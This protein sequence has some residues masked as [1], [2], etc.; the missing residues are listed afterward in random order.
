MK[1]II[2]IFSTV[3]LI[4]ISCQLEP[5]DK[6][7]KNIADDDSE[8]EKITLEEASSLFEVE[9]ENC[10]I[11]ETNSTSYL[12]KNGCTLWC[13]K[14]TNETENFEEINVEV[15]KESGK[16]ETG[17]GIIF[18]KQSVNEK[19]FFVTVMINTQG[20][21]IIGKVLDGKFEIISNWQSTK[22]LNKGYGI[23]NKISVREET[24]KF[25]I[26]FNGYSIKD[27]LI[28]EKI[29]YKGSK[30]GY[31]AVIASNENIPEEKVKIVLR[32]E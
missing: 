13:T 11:F 8:D 25:R 18:L 23:K 1:K 2:L 31:V 10:F 5:F 6:S 20:Q 27:F 21:Y 15:Y 4:F 29:S 14:S 9:N 19:D 7:I 24:G 28:E 22:Y 30:K 32:Q 3:F 17:F 12:K 16:A 26:S